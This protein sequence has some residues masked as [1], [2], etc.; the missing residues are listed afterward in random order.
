MNESTISRTVKNKYIKFNNKTIPLSFFFTSKTKDKLNVKNSSSISIKAKIKK[1]ITSEEQLDIILSD[2][3]IVNLL[4][5]EDIM[6]SRRT[7][8]K[9]RESLNIPSSLVR[10]KTF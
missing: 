10:S 7:V 1:L 5:K 9:Y 2:Q 3:K 8:N 6:I 4:K